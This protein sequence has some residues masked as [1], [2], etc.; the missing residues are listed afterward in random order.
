MRL[1]IVLHKKGQEEVAISVKESLHSV[2]LK[3]FS[4]ALVKSK[5]LNMKTVKVKDNKSSKS[6]T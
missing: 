6:K 4:N 3:I 5:T 2:C 1:E